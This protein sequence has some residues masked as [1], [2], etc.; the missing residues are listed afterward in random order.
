MKK[1]AIILVSVFGIMFIGAILE[2]LCLALTGEFSFEF[3]IFGWIVQISYAILFLG[4][5]ILAADTWLESE[6]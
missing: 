4:L 5:G 1:V 2:G 6:L 3:T